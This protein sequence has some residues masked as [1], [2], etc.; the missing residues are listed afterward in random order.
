VIFI[1]PTRGDVYCHFGCLVACNLMVLTQ[2]IKAYFQASKMC[3]PALVCEAISNAT[4]TELLRQ[5]HFSGEDAY[6][7]TVF[8]A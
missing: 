5:F 1:I 4:I 6:V 8:L 3:F 2:T 7:G